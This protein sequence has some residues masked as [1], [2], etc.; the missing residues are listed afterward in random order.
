SEYPVE[1]IQFHPE[2]IMTKVGKDL[3]QNFL[4]M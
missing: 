2:S 1:G 4:D 3:L